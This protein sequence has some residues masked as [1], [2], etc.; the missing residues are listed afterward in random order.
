[1]ARGDNTR[2]ARLV[3]VLAL[4]LALLMGAVAI[5]TTLVWPKGESAKL[6]AGAQD[7]DTTATGDIVT[8]EV[9]TT[10]E[11]T[12]PADPVPVF[13]DHEEV[14]ELLADSPDAPPTP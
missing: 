14:E 10:E 1:M 6:A 9:P 3:K 13:G 2:N 8:E 11:A 7:R 4:A 12:P 5:P